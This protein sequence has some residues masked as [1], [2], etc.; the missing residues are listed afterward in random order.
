MNDFRGL[1][2]KKAWFTE[3]GHEGDVVIS[4]LN[5]NRT[6]LCASINHEASIEFY[7]VVFASVLH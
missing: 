2:E 7:E 6:P 1:L 4:K 5:V 3:S